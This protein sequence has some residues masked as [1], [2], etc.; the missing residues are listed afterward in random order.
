[1]Y[2]LGNDI[3]YG[4]RQLGKSPCFTVVVVLTLGLVIGV[5]STLFTAVNYQLFRPLPIEA[6]DHLVR[7]C[8]TNERGGKGLL[9][10]AAR[11]IEY[12]RR[13]T[14]FVGLAA[15][16]AKTMTLTGSG[17]ARHFQ[18][19]RVS[20]S[21]FDVFGF[22]PLLG[23]GFSESAA[24]GPPAQ[25]V[26]IGYATWRDVFDRDPNVLGAMLS[27]DQQMYTVIGVMPKDLARIELGW[28]GDLWI[29]WDFARPA[30]GDSWFAVIGRLKPAIAPEQAQS[31]L[32]VLGRAIENMHDPRG[33]YDRA[34]A[35]PY[36]RSHTS[37]EEIAGAAFFVMTVVFVLLIACVNVTNLFIARALTR[38]RELAVRLSLG[39]SRARLVRQLLVEFGIFAALGGLLG[40]LSAKWTSDVLDA[41]GLADLT[42]DWR[43]IV[44]TTGISLLAGATSGLVPALRFSK[45]NLTKGLK[46]GG[47]VTSFGRGHHRLR[48]GLVI[49][50]M[51]MVTV[52]LITS[53]LMIRS[54]V[55]LGR[56]H[57]GYDTRNLVTVSVNLRDQDYPEQAAK[58]LFLQRTL[59]NLRALPAVEDAGLTSLAAVSRNPGGFPFR[60]QG[61]SVAED[62]E[63]PRGAIN[64]VDANFLRMVEARVLKGRIITE[65]DARRSAGVAVIN[66]TLARRYFSG[67]DPLGR[68]VELHDSAAESQWYE[69]IGVVA[70]LK[71]IA[72]DETPF[73]EVFIPYMQ[74]ERFPLSHHLMIRTATDPLAMAGALREAV[75]SANPNQPVGN[76]SPVESQI[77]Q[78]RTW[79][80]E[81]RNLMLLF[82]ALGFALSMIGMYGV[83]SHMVT[84]RT[85][86]MGVRIALGAVQ[87][88]VLMLVLRQ[89]LR[90]VAIGG[91]IGACLALGSTFVLDRLLYAVSPADPVTYGAVFTLVGSAAVVASLLPAR[92]AARIDPMKALRHE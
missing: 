45:P 23:R 65:A 9:L 41:R 55:K 12:R 70:D 64:A 39:A 8:R 22:E 88:D 15:M 71:N 67:Q 87:Q 5:C 24:E 69:I 48:S 59:E 28:A 7:L 80:D 21:L 73:A 61:Q 66:E 4:V 75:L 29:P 81:I 89:S 30:E 25:E 92:R 38:R 27:L 53:G 32:L 46:E 10:N 43:V 50:Q 51:A 90:P 6:P 47:L 35:V 58:Q 84:E 62:R 33:T 17:E 57:P 14:A 82:G 26:V 19:A 77:R 40:L 79:N 31:E 2:T 44:F 86:E 52:L 11:F 16:D 56:I 54:F 74:L 34:T 60:I 1:M 83:V 3:R 18:V 20:P 36:L 63:S 49:T 37:A 91:V 72:F 42:F 85:R 13:S 76:V 68:F 78:L